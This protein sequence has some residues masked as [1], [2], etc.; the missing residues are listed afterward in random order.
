MAAL[1][2]GADAI[3]HDIPG[4]ASTSAFAPRQ[5][6]RKPVPWTALVVDDWD[7]LRAAMGMILENLGFRVRE[8]ANGSAALAA[9]E[10]E[11]PAV[12][13]LDVK[14]PIMDGRAFLEKIRA[15]P[16]GTGPRIVLCSGQEDLVLIRD[17][18]GAGA[19]GHL[20]KPFDER[21]LKEALQ[22][23]GAM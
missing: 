18:M 22:K 10:A 11:M 12:V 13:L 7:L 8:A 4:S 6:D 2:T 3:R 15:M 1:L 21:Q 5:T 23:I 16:G 9:C 17:A 20:F 14:M 19:D